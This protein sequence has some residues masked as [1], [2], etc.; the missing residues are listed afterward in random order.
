M[1]PKYY[2]SLNGQTSKM[3]TTDVIFTEIAVLCKDFTEVAQCSI[4]EV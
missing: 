3:G 4:T 1:N 2:V